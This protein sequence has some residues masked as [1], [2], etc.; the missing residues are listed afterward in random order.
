VTWVSDAVKTRRELRRGRRYRKTPYR[1]CRPNRLQGQLRL[2]PSTRTRWG[3]KLRLA[4]WLAHL[5]PIT[6][7]VVEDIKAPTK[8]TR[9]WDASF[10][11]L[12]VG[13]HW[14]YAELA[15]VAPVQTRSGWETKEL[16][17]ALGLRK[18]GNKMSDQFE[19]HCVDSWV[20]ANEATGG[21]RAPEHTRILFITPLRFHRRQLHR[22]QPAAGGVRKPYGGT[23]SLG[24]K[25]GSLVKHPKYGLAYVGGYLKESLSLHSL[26]DGK[27]LTQKAKAAECQFLAFSS[28]RYGNSSH[29]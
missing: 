25:R 1:Q 14:F 17:E 19:A 9:K 8:G 20:L 16:R 18:S 3:W 12:E 10:S 24:F 27:R 4:A 15:K 26:A 13:K 28:W 5:Y 23:R 2:P 6:Q 7:F 21:H 11:P 29:D 22:M